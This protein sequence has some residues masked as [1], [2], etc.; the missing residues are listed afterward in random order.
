MSTLPTSSGERFGA[1]AKAITSLGRYSA[2]APLRLAGPPVSSSGRYPHRSMRLRRVPGPRITLPT[3][4]TFEA[5]RRP[6]CKDGA[7]SSRRGAQPYPGVHSTRFATSNR[8]CH[9]AG[10][11]H[12]PLQNPGAA[13]IICSTPK[14]WFRRPKL[15]RCDDGGCPYLFTYIWNDPVVFD[16]FAISLQL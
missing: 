6:A 11:R 8:R 13:V 3:G 5:S 12:A 9:Y 4:S 1:I 16:R 10:V 14:E 7:P 2:T 15:L